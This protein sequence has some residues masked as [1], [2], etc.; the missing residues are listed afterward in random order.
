MNFEGT[1]SANAVTGTVAVSI[2]GQMS[3]AA[4]ITANSANSVQINSVAMASAVAISATSASG[5]VVN[6]DEDLILS[7]GNLNAVSQMTVDTNGAFDF[8]AFGLTSFESAE[9]NGSGSAVLGALGSVTNTSNMTVEASGLTA[10]TVGD[11]NTRGGS[12]SLDTTGVIGITTIGTTINADNG[13]ANLGDVSL[14]FGL[15]GYNAAGAIAVTGTNVSVDLSSVIVEPPVDMT[16]TVEESFAFTGSA[17]VDSGSHTIVPAG[18]ALAISL[19]SSG[20]LDDAIMV[21]N[22]AGNATQITVQGD[23]GTDGT[24]GDT[25]TIN[26]TG[27]GA[28][29]SV[30]ASGLTKGSLLV[31]GGNA[32]DTI[33]GGA[34]DDV[35]TGN[36]GADVLSGGGGDDTFN[37]TTTA[38]DGSDTIDGGN[39]NADTIAVGTGSTIVFSA[40]DSNI[41]D[42][43]NITVGS[44]GSVTL[45]GQTEDFNITGNTGAEVLVGGA[46]DDFISGGTQDDRIE[47]GDGADTLSGGAGIDTFVLTATAEA[48]GDVIQ[49]WLSGTDELEVSISTYDSGGVLAA[50]GMGNLIA[51]EFDTQANAAAL[52]GG[53]VEASTNSALF[54]H[55]QDTGAIYYNADGATAGGL[56]QILDVGSA[57]TVVDGDWTIVA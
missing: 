50:I 48:H 14:A 5:L 1:I 3:G 53:S 21:T 26:S 52:T 23:L 46:G 56:V 9:F 31:T 25:V 54:I 47:G 7:A 43:E 37:V 49:D 42:V 2:D 44:G 20:A 10:F 39:G 6:A 12:I 32:I 22:T 29:I 11:M 38:D 16:H 36:V 13:A 17:V 45:T 51:A 24:S 4:A 41:Q 35:I 34:D 28:A 57:S 15:M 33:V 40:T 27:V 30:N 19:D 55:L 18:T 8:S